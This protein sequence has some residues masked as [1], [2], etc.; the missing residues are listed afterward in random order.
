ML[1]SNLKLIQIQG[2]LKSAY[3]SKDLDKFCQ[4]LRRTGIETELESEKDDKIGFLENFLDSLKLKQFQSSRKL[5]F[6]RDN[7]SESLFELILKSSDS[8][9]YKFISLIWAEY[10]FWNNCEILTTPNYLKKLPID[11]VLESN[12]D[13]NLFAF[14]VFDF[15]HESENVSKSSKKYFLTLKNDQFAQK[16][17]K[18]LF[19]HLYSIIDDEN[20]EVCLDLIAKMLDEMKIIVD[21]RK[22]TAIDEVLSVNNDHLKNKILNILMKHW[23]MEIIIFI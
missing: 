15:E 22:E 6:E 18:N 11:Y 12:D 1:N 3:N 2:Q 7:N 19:Q 20:E 4:I 14:L 13:E 23:K 10:E 16:T 8:G 21:I 17:G 5:L 9:N